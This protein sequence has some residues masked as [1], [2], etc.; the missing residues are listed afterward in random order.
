MASGTITSLG[1]GSSLDL[2]NI[3]DSL[4]KG[5]EAVITQKEE[6]KTSLE[7]T[8]QAFNS[9]NAKMLSMKSDALNLSLSSNYLE[10]DISVS[11]SDI[12]NATVADGA[13]ASSHNVTVSRLASSHSFLSAGKASSDHTVYVPTTQNSAEGFADTDTTSVLAED[14]EMTVAYGTGDSRQTITITGDAGGMTLDEM[15]DAI[16]NDT[17]NDDG[18]GSTYVDASTYTDDN[19]D[20][21]LR[22][23]ATSG[24]TGEENRVMVTD[25]PDATG[26]SAPDATF[27]Y[28][29]GDSENIS[30]SVSADTSL[31]DLASQ[32][33]DD[34]DNPGITASII[35]TGTGD[36]PYRLA[37]KSDTTGESSRI[38]ITSQLDD[39]ALTEENGAGYSMESDTALS[40][41][42][43]I[44]IRESDGNNEIVFQEDSGS[45]FSSNITAT[46][47]DGVYDN[48]DDLASAVEEA[49][50]AA[51]Q[52]AGNGSDYMV[53]FDS[54]S[55]KLRIEEAGTLE[56]VKIN[57][58]DAG[59]TSASDL[60]FSATK[61]LTPE[62][63]SLNASVTVDGIAY[64]RQDNSNV[65]DILSGVTL[66]L[67]KTGD[68]GISIDRNTSSVQENIS[69]FV[70]KF[71]ELIQEIDKKDDFNEETEEWGPLAKTPSIRGARQNLMT[72]M[73]TEI[74]TGG[75]ITSLYDL[76]FDVD[77][78]GNVSI[79]EQVLSGKIS[80]D[81]EG[82]KSF[83]LGDDD[84]AGMADRLNDRLKEY[85][86][87][88]GIID[89][90]TDAVAD[91]ISR[92]EE[93]IES[94]TERLDKRY[95]TMTQE[96]VALDNY[97]REME[98]QQNFISEMADTLGSSSKNG[99]K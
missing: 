91:R 12:L 25:P 53:S 52:T 15:V 42:D 50:E 83:F 85:T 79:D 43:P 80:S 76:G 54:D 55:S 62:A 69:G 96:F 1:V 8:K 26:F 99:S 14:E 61:T 64:Q 75:E 65:D 63:S 41:A 94:E 21:H 31:S 44:V 77:K 17:E 57:W 90:E 86:K 45:G 72:V 2:Q 34:A 13:E 88:S 89:S 71:G 39:L 82:V 58:G 92:I 33:N 5:D 49:L 10:N 35:D 23:E 20:Y 74:D 68:T 93:Q 84:T 22:V 78:Q 67:S 16:N 97:M 3:L 51:S 7:N 29:L 24:G 87:S 11:S 59:S 18:Q 32:I 38:N 48:G 60:G 56:G 73:T 46:I 66:N 98:S 4:R 27:A 6:K 70:K 95:E 28:S 37:L 40:F 19:G 9:I 30:V 36:T 81:F 47:E